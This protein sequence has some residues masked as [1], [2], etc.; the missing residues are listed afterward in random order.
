MQIHIP[1][2]PTDFLRRVRED[3]RDD[4]GQPVERLTAEGGEPC[5]DVLRRARPG[6]ELILASFSPFAGPGPFREFGPVYVL[7][8]PEPDAAPRDVLPLPAGDDT[9]Y[10]QEHFVLR[11]YDDDQSILDGAWVGPAD[12]T[13]RLSEL[14]Q[15]PEVA[16]V[17]VRFPVAGCFAC[18]IERAGTGATPGLR[19]SEPWTAHQGAAA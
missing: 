18:R 15:R 12:A 5:R 4:L 10:L 14:L 9:D 13:Q 7:A 3:G 19:Y 16:F 2:L 8:A 17:D 11:A 1:V 6:E